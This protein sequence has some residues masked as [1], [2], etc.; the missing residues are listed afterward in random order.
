MEKKKNRQWELLMGGS[1]GCILPL[2]VY[3]HLKAKG[4][5]VFGVNPI[6][7]L[8]SNPSAKDEVIPR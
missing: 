1:N 5:T 8:V 2:A 7:I 3:W 6:P 4:L